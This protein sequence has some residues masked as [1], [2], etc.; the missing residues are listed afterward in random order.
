MEVL[1]VAPFSID[2]CREL[3]RQ[4]VHTF[5]LQPVELV[6]EDPSVSPH[7]PDGSIELNELFAFDVS[8]TLEI[9]VSP[10]GVEK[11][12]ELPGRLAD[13]YL[14]LLRMFKDFQDRAKVVASSS[15]NPV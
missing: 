11:P 5:A 2:V 12:D 15:V 14:E 13:A 10:V 9:A 3:D 4:G 7:L 8:R 1:G 6:L